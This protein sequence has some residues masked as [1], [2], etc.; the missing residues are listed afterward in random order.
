MLTLQTSSDRRSFLRAG[1]LG[2]AGLTL[3]D[4]LRAQAAFPSSIR[5]KSVIF[6]FLQGGPS[7]IE[8]FDPKMTAPAE[9]RITTGETATSLPGVTF[10]STFQRLAKLAHK[11]NVVRSFQGGDGN[12][13][14]KPIV[15]KDTLNANLGSIFARL[16]GN[17]H[18][19]T[20][21]PTNVALFPRAV[22]PDAGPEQANFGNFLG[23]GTLGGAYAPYAPGASGPQLDNLRLKIAP[24]RFDDRRALVEQFDALRRATDGTDITDRHRAQALDMILRGAADA[25][26]LSKEPARVV[27]RYDTAA[28]ASADSIPKKWNNHKHYVDHVR[29]LGK[30]MLMARRLCEAGVNFVTVTTNFVWDMHADQN[31]APP[32]EAMRYVGGPLDHAVSAFIEDCEARGLGEKILLV[33]TGEMGRSPKINKNGGRD[34][35]GESTPLLLYGGGLPSGQVI[36]QSTS[37]GGRPSSTPIK[38]ANLIST[39]WHTLFD[40]GQVRVQRGVPD[41]VMRVVTGGSPIRELIDA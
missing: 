21:M 3:P 6:L 2:L 39:I 38:R 33:V 28:L 14:I 40:V 41:D 16:A 24:E 18:P 29:S 7:Q 35:W 34:H 32:G 12:H 37:D 1:A 5:D 23:T 13:D 31:N 10:G 8:T 27:E 22:V 4:M 25:F 19:T 9:I 20:G 11:F 36:G 26:D 17:N 30:L 15:A